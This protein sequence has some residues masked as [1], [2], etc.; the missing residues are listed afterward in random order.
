MEQN[1]F[2]NKSFKQIFHI[3]DMKHKIV[4]IPLITEYIPSNNILKS[5]LHIKD[6]YTRLNKT[7]LTFFQRL[8]EQPAFFSKFYSIYKQQRKHL[9]PLTGFVYFFSIDQ[10]HQYNAQQNK[11]H[12]YMTDLEFK[13]IPK[14]FR[15][16]ISTI[17]NKKQTNSDII[18]LHIYNNSPYKITPIKFRILRNKCNNPPNRRKSI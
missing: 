18:S 13:P 17:K 11:Q 12:L 10:V 16:A 2:L 6:K 9:K 5:K 14:F 4:G 1:Q 7:L 15:G 8:I 3:T